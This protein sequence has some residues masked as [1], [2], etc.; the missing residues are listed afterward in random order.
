MP[1]RGRVWPASKINLAT[2]HNT[3]AL[4]VLKI[5]KSTEPQ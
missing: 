2:S 1:E 5:I 4:A 3:V